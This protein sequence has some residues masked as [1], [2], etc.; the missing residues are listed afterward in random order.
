MVRVVGQR[1]SPG[2]NGDISYRVPVGVLY[3]VVGGWDSLCFRDKANFSTDKHDLMA[4]EG[5]QSPIDG[6]GQYHG[7][8][9]GRQGLCGIH[10]NI[11]KRSTRCDRDVDIDD[12]NGARVI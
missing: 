7:Y 12:N 11:Y 6:G 3:K 9:C 1:K 5:E 2:I 10:W 4:N 8:N